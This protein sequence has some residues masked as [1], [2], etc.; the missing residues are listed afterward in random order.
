M[1][2]VT[3]AGNAGPRGMLPPG[4]TPGFFHFLSTIHPWTTV[5]PQLPLTAN[6]QNKLKRMSSAAL[7]HGERPVKYW[8]Q[9]CLA[10]EAITSGAKMFSSLQIKA[11]GQN[12]DMLLEG[13]VTMSSISRGPA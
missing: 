8:F 13:P 4:G 12:A 6:K 10:E 7:A 1:H 11:L 9:A 3:I 5:E 2:G